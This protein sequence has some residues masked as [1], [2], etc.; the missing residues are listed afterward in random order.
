MNFIY[1]VEECGGPGGRRFGLNL[2][3]EL[4]KLG[5]LSTTNQPNI[6]AIMTI[7]RVIK[8]L[9]IASS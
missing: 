8:L 1:S 6:P 5:Y 2:R 4:S 9:V 7:S 3:L